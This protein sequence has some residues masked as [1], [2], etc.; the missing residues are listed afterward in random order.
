MSQ[1]A[2]VHV[3]KNCGNLFNGNYCNEC[4]EKVILPQDRSFRTFLNSM[5]LALTFA[6]NR[7][8]RTLWVIIKT[9]GFLSREFAEG[10]RVKYLKPLSMFFFLNLIYFLFPLIQLFNASLRTQLNSF[11]S[12]VAATT[13]ARK[14]IELGVNDV[15]SFSIIYDQKTTRFAKMLVI[16]FAVLASLPLNL[17]YR[18]RQRYFTD[19]VGLS[20]ELVCF[21]LLINAIFLT[22]VVNLAHLGAY[23]DEFVLTSIF[24]VTN[25][26][27][28][29][30]SGF[31]FYD[32][33]GVR[34]V[35][36]SIL[37]IAVLRVTLEV[38]RM[39]LF[40]VTIW[41]L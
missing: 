26:F 14:M 9:P 34:L 40:Y 2:G 31:I 32:E 20:V 30:R 38:Y 17:M 15:N 37:M 10:R 11:H 19:H 18:S 35:L 13:V 23:L 3:C 12:K 7:F 25:L 1:P 4:G 28:L 5:F 41:S 33:R 27:F 8:V 24:I 36:K 22:L 21:N 39:V 16:V 29:F 6:D